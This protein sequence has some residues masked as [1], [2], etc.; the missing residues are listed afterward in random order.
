MNESK[1]EK[2]I[3]KTVGRN[4]I[5]IAQARNDISEAKKYGMM[6]ISNSSQS[7]RNT[8]KVK[9]GKFKGTYAVD[10]DLINTMSNNTGR[11]NYRLGIDKKGNEL[12][13]FEHTSD[14]SYKSVVSF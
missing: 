2:L 14:G 10:L 13:V 7:Y 8:H 11:G 3:N 6:S 9:T 12:Y 1:L 5:S 4:K